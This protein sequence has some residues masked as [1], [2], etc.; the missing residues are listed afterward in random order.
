MCYRTAEQA[1][2]TAE[3]DALEILN[4]YLQ[5]NCQGPERRK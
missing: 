3:P 2:R 1:K 5:R 4:A